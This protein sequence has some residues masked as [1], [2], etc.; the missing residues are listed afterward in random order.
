[1][2]RR[3]VLFAAVSASLAVVIFWIAKNTSWVDVRVPMP[4]RGEAL[5]NP[6]YAVQRFAET[7]GVR[8]RWDRVFMHPPADSVI[9]LSSWHWSLSAGRREALEAWVEAGGRLVVDDRITG[10]EAEFQRWSGIF[11]NYHREAQDAARAD[12]HVE[13][14][15]TYYEQHDAAATSDRGAPHILCDFESASFLRTTRP[16]VWILRDSSGIQ[17]LRVSVGRGSVT[18]INASPFRYRALFD[19]EHGWLFVAAT[20]LR[21]GDAVY[22]LSEDDHASLLALIWQ[23]GAPVVVLALALVALGLWRDAVR[24]G[25]L[26]PAEPAGRRSLG[27][28]VRGTA[29]F[30]LRYGTGEPLH[31]ASV[32]ALDEAAQR[33]V[34]RYLH[35]AAA[36]RAAA[37]ASLTGFDANAL[38][39]AMY[40]PEMRRASEL[41]STIA[42]L[43][44]ARRHIVTRR[45]S[46]HGAF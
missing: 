39:E 9:V 14:C 7:L 35:L 15:H 4:P 45:T 10:G 16:A 18:V 23:H 21:R 41:R 34:P 1:M 25:P 36:Q 5:T 24:F 17:A 26:A 46:S 12:D 43:E 22:F 29:R 11:R 32:R 3:A 27:E 13:P 20:E 8:T 40:H 6:F 42:L 37:L 2:S 28:Q 38:A 30:V 33:R 44:A 19:G 31:A